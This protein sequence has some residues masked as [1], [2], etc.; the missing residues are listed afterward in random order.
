MHVLW[1]RLPCDLWRLAFPLW[2]WVSPAAEWKCVARSSL[3]FSRLWQY[4]I[5]GFWASRGKS[6]FQSCVPEAPCL[7]WAL[8]FFAFGKNP[9]KRSFL[10]TSWGC[11]PMSSLNNRSPDWQAQGNIQSRRK[12][13][14]HY[15]NPIIRAVNTSIYLWALAESVFNCALFFY[16]G[17]TCQMCVTIPISHQRRDGRKKERKLQL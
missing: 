1:L 15:W 11:T 9:K 16:T 17:S 4:V 12:R 5:S 6:E 2:L 3:W 14:S 10:Q 8:L 13:P 7:T